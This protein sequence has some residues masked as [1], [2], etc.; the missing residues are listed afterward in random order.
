MTLAYGNKPKSAQYMK[1]PH[2]VII[3]KPEHSNEIVLKVVVD[4]ETFHA[5]QNIIKT[6]TLK[7]FTEE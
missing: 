4:A 6:F 3:A 7:K 2:Y 5:I 1:T